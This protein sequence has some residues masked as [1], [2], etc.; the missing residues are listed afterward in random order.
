[1][2]RR[3]SVATTTSVVCSPSTNGSGSGNGGASGGAVE[4]ASRRPSSPTTSP[5]AL[6]IASAPTTASSAR[7]DADPRPPGTRWSAPFHFPTVAPAP[8]PTC[9]VAS[10]PPCS[11]AVKAATPSSGPGRMPPEL[12]RSYTAAAGTIGTFPPAVE[13]PRPCASSDRITPSAAASPN[14]DPPASTTASTFWTSRCGSSSAVSRL[15]GAPPRT[16][17]DAIVPSGTVTTVTPVPSPVQWP[18]PMPETSVIR[19][20]PREGRARHGRAGP[21]VAAARTAAAARRHRDRVRTPR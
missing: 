2:V 19:R 9:P 18:T 12:T 21:L 13:K 10:G 8:A 6:T 7:A 20:R 11:A 4:P 14:A 3:A 15:A 17:P 1:M 16:S 5:I